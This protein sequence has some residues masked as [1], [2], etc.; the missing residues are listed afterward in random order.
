MGHLA[1]IARGRTLITLS[2]GVCNGKQ[3]GMCCNVLYR[4]NARLR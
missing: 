4:Q 2:F 1:A 3:E